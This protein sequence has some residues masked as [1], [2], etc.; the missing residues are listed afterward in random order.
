MR[1]L[2]LFSMPSETVFQHLFPS[3]FPPDLPHK[4]LACMPSD[5]ALTGRR[6]ELFRESWQSIASAHNA[7]FLYIDNS[8]LDA[9]EEQRK[10][11]RANILMITGGNCCVLLR[12]LRR[13]G[14][15][16]AV[17]AFARKDPSIIAGYS[18]GAM[19]CTP[20][21]A[22]AASGPGE[23]ENLGVGLTN[24][25]ALRLVDYEILPHYTDDMRAF[26]ESY[27]K[28]AAH[29]VRPLRDDEFIILER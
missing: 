2:I 18:A 22:L 14:L 25:E 4:V 13:S 6:Y 10:L 26:Y 3:L 15:D 9:T 19:V 20:S 12:N 29:P 24:F 27:A 17:L 1:C 5:G 23:N 7:E 11:S 28:A 16:K 21:V 8:V